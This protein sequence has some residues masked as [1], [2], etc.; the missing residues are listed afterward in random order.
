MEGWKGGFPNGKSF[1]GDSRND[2][3][4]HVVFH[5]LIGDFPLL[6]TVFYVTQDFSLKIVQKSQSS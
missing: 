2:F 6:I 5:V 3:P 4:F 1:L